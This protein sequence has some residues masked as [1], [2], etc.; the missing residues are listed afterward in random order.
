[1]IFPLLCASLFDIVSLTS[2][3]RVI[4]TDSV[5][6]NPYRECSPQKI[7]KEMTFQPVQGF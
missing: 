2:E 3:E 1:M 6:K 7:K 5:G 4:F